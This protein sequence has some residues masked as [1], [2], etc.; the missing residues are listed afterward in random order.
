M[1][2]VSHKLLVVLF[3]CE[4][5]AVTPVCINMITDLILTD[6]K[7]LYSGNLAYICGTL[8]INVYACVS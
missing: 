8:F 1:L 4:L 5:F 3:I 7:Q 6:M 2:Q